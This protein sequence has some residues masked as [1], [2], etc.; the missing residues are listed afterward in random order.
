MGGSFGVAVFGAI[1]TSRLATE[2]PRLLPAGA[3]PDGAAS[4]L[5][6]PAQ[7]RRLPGPV[8]DAVA[9]ALARSLHSVFLWTVPVLLLGFAVCWLLDE[10]PLRPQAPAAAADERD[11]L[12][13]ATSAAQR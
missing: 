1:L 6:S 12:V 7:I 5:N 11:Q 8:A 2:L 9:E 10:L 13:A 4:V 3:S